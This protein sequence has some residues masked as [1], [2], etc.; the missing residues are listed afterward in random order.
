VGVPSHELIV[1][2]FFAARDEPT[3]VGEERARRTGSL[4]NLYPLI[5]HEPTTNIPWH[6]VP[7]LV[8]YGK[9]QPFPGQME[10]VDAAKVVFTNLSS[11]PEGGGVRGQPF[12]LSHLFSKHQGT[13]SLAAGSS[14][15]LLPANRFRKQGCAQFKLRKQQDKIADM[16]LLKCATL[17]LGTSSCKDAHTAARD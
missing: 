10:T 7:S 8:F 12:S 2:K 5:R 9:K 1:A 17:K 15:N 3:H 4:A 14:R 16:P 6:P 11:Y 13:A